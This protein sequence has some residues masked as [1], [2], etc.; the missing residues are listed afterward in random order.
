MSD[1]KVLHPDLSKVYAKWTVAIGGGKSPTKWTK[2]PPTIRK[3]TAKLS[4]IATGPRLVRTSALAR[5]ERQSGFQRAAFNLSV[6]AQV[7]LQVRISAEEGLSPG[8]NMCA[9]SISNRPSPLDDRDYKLRSQ[10]QTCLCHQPGST[11]FATPSP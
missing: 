1:V 7:W 5:G 10:T 8:V 4:P 6:Q 2:K 3:S 11:V 9:N